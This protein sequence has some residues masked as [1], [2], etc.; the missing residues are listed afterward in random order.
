MPSQR[1]GIIGA[2][3]CGYVN[4]QLIRAIRSGDLLDADGDAI[5]TRTT[6][7]LPNSLCVLE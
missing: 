5:A 2:A 4:R 6:D 7:N 3:L 1:L